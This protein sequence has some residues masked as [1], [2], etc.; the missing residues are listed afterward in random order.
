MHNVPVAYSRMRRNDHVRLSVALIF[1][2]LERSP[3]PRGREISNEQAHFTTG[4]GKESVLAQ[5]DFDFLLFRN[6]L[7]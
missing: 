1:N 7:I 2:R 3:D 4:Y 6:G 5:F